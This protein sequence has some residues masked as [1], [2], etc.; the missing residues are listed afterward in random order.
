[1]NK[2]VIRIAVPL[3]IVVIAIFAA[4]GLSK[5]RKP[6]EKVSEAKMG[7]L[8]HHF[9]QALQLRLGM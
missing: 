1:M 2:K 3:L 4:V 5:A 9:C 6:P 7:G 8:T